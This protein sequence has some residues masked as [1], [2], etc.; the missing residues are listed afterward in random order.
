MKKKRF[1]YIGKKEALGSERRDGGAKTY[2]P[3][4][5]ALHCKGGI[6]WGGEGERKWRVCKRSPPSARRD[7]RVPNIQ[8]RKSEKGLEKRP[9]RVTSRTGGEGRRDHPKAFWERGTSID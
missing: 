4:G 7:R 8:D 9:R 1:P 3:W 6:Y 5:G 2:V